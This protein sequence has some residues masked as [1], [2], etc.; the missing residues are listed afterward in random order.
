MHLSIFQTVKNVF[1]IVV[2][3]IKSAMAE[4]VGKKQNGQNSPKKKRKKK[5]LHNEVDSAMR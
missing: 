2:E 5:S 3:Q 4:A 1:W